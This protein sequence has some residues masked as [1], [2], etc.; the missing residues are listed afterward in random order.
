M[1]P[2]TKQ[3]K[4][5]TYRRDFPEVDKL[6]LRLIAETD[7]RSVGDS[8]PS[9]INRCTLLYF[10]S[11]GAS[12][13]PS[14]DSDIQPQGGRL[15][16]FRWNTLPVISGRRLSQFSADRRPHQRSASPQDGR[17]WRTRSTLP[18]IPSHCYGDRRRLLLPGVAAQDCSPHRRDE[19][20][21]G[22][23]AWGTAGGRPWDHCHIGSVLWSI[24]CYD[25]GT[26]AHL[27]LGIYTPSKPS[28]HWL[29]PQ[30]SCQI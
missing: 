28:P 27:H 29:Q 16:G 18:G 8:H 2:P 14:G 6:C 30:I 25:A 24:R 5:T 10:T 20:A 17:V 19:P 9:C 3:V 13:E 12:Q 1:P 11:D 23:V 21:V 7:A 4:A 15:S 22:T 26:A